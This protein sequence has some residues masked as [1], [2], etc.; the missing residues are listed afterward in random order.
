LTYKVVAAISESELSMPREFTPA[1]FLL[2]ITCKCGPH[3]VARPEALAKL[4]ARARR[5]RQS[6]SGCGARSAARRRQ[7]SGICEA[8]AA[9]CA[10]E[11]ESVKSDGE[12]R[13]RPI[14]DR[15][16]ASLTSMLSVVNEDGPSAS[17]RMTDAML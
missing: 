5:S 3:R 12:M 9:P 15:S 1:H 14:Y 10:E 13:A 11:S 17:I 4:C 7:G 6:A 16:A 8:Q 2:R